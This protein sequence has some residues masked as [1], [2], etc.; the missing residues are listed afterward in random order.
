MGH[1]YFPAQYL[2]VLS[3]HYLMK[4]HLFYSEIKLI[5]WK[6]YHMVLRTK[7]EVMIG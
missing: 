4:S 6:I 5:I 2:S 1:F 7:N 3:S